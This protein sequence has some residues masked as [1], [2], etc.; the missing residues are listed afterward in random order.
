MQLTRRD[1][2][3]AIAGLGGAG[4]VAAE[5]LGGDQSSP[6]TEAHVGRLV[7]V[8]DVIYPTAV[9]VDESFVEA[10]V[11]GR[12]A[13]RPVYL[14]GVKEGLEHIERAATE[15]YG[16][17]YVDLPVGRREDVLERI[18]VKRVQP[19]PDG[20]TAERV[21]YYVINDLLYALYSTP[22]GGNL[23]GRSNP[24]G[25]PGGLEAYQRG[26]ER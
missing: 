17:T 7:G 26:P 4:A 21:R 19:R 15:W 23:L 9:T 13:G 14:A 10:Y 12:Y 11:T 25:Y 3:I 8:A 1:A 2:L 5:T 20:R 6:I 16:A 24:Q 18:G 22:V